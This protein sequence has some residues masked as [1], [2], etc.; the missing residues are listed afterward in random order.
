MKEIIK[1]LKKLPEKIRLGGDYNI[2]QYALL[3]GLLAKNDISIRNYNRGKDTSLTISFLNSVGGVV[4]RSATEILVRGDSRIQIDDCAELEYKGGAV[5]LAMI[6]GFLAGKKTCCSLVYSNKINPDLID[7]LVGYFNKY[8]I[9]IFHRAE[10]NQIYFRAGSESPVECTLSNAL[11][12][13]KDSL[14]IYSLTCGQSILIKE[15]AATDSGFEKLITDLGGALS[16]EET[17]SVMTTDPDDPRKR[18]RV[19]SYDYKRKIFLKKSSEIGGGELNVPSDFNSLAAFLLLAILK[20][21]KLT[22]ENAY[23]KDSMGRFLKFLK[24]FAAEVGSGNR[25]TVGNYTVY[26]ISIDGHEAKGRKL[27]GRTATGLMELIPFITI[28][29]AVG[30]GNTVIRDV[31]EYGVWRNNPFYEISVALGRLGIKSGA[32]ED[33][34]VIE[35]KPDYEDDSFGP[36]DNRETALA[37]YMLTLS[38]TVKTTFDGFELV[39]DNYPEIVEEVQA[40]YERQLLSRSA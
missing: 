19:D 39:G 38:E 22:I 36:F 24:T 15:K 14:L 8:S 31:S 13:L 1:P 26:D 28:A 5:P 30:N 27:S 10:T 37:F 32:L 35:G 21:E 9:D 33:G 17:K 16:C 18:I 12:Y 3:L 4:E 34:L 2:T 25:K 23:I 29:A 40:A 11:P 7:F 6:I 20:K